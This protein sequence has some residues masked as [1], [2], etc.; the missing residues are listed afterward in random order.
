MPLYSQA[1]L[2][3]LLADVAD[4]L[5]D[6]HCLHTL[7]ASVE[8]PPPPHS[9]NR[10][11]VARTVEAYASGL[12][13]IL[14]AFSTDLLQLEGQLATQQQRHA[15]DA[16]NISGIARAQTTL[17]SLL[18][19]KLAGWRGQL[20]YLRQLHQLALPAHAQSTKSVTAPAQTENWLVS[21]RILSVLYN[22]LA[23]VLF[24]EL[25]PSLLDLFLRTVRPYFRQGEEVPLFMNF[26]KF[27]AVWSS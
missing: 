15:H 24:P 21:V 19:N 9:S 6:L 20:S 17:V 5:S 2:H 12:A 18:L 11:K 22:A 13:N 8:R 7:I 14:T 3:G 25:M 27:Y 16:Q 26:L 1:A 23:G 10:P 4:T